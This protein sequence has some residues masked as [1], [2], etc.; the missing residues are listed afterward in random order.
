MRPEWQNHEQDQC[1]S[2][3]VLH[4]HLRMLGNTNSRVTKR[5]RIESDRDTAGSYTRDCTENRCQVLAEAN[6]PYSNSFIT[7]A[8]L[9]NRSSTFANTVPPANEPSPFRCPAVMPVKISIPSSIVA[10]GQM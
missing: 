7:R 8:I 2:R 4:G 3:T 9:P 1:A 5:T 6:S 10:T